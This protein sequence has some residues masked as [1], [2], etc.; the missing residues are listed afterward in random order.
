M[1]ND[2]LRLQWTTGNKIAIRV[3]VSSWNE[4]LKNLDCH[5]FCAGGVQNIN[6]TKLKVI[7]SFFLSILSHF[8]AVLITHWPPIPGTVGLKRWYSLFIC[9]SPSIYLSFA[10]GPLPVGAWCLGIRLFL[11]I[12]RINIHLDDLPRH[13]HVVAVCIY[14]Q[15]QRLQSTWTI[16]LDPIHP[17]SNFITA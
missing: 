1:S 7:K 17:L 12:K 11:Y 16:S 10:V 6:F 9:A 5:I 2:A 14:G 13:H 8:R 4:K 15:I 3:R